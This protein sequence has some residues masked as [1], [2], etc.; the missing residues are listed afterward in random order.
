M[1]NFGI[2]TL[3]ESPDMKD[4]AKLCNELGLQFVELNMNLPQYEPDVID[5]SR[6]RRVARDYDIFY[7]LHLDENLNPWDFNGHVQE[8]YTRTVLDCIHVAQK[9]DI[10]VLNMHLVYG[11]YFTLPDKRV[12]LFDVFRSHYLDTVRAF[13][14]KCESAIGNS[15]VKILIENCAGYPKYQQAALDVLLES[16]AFGLTLDIGHNHG[17]E[18][19]DEPFITERIDR[20]AHMHIHDAIGKRDH[21]VLGE[22]DIDLQKYFSM[23]K[24]HVE[25]AVIETKTVESLR[26]SIPWMR[27]NIK[28]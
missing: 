14:D 9:L 13:R 12:Y 16:P 7:T 5:I 20:L 26:K 4:C 28:L 25:T 2:P 3:I 18:Y 27:E 21:M 8:A 23:A 22:G 1:L 17:S 15:G 11:V 6:V 10:S 24:S 19:M